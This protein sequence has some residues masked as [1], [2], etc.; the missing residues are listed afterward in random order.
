MNYLGK[1]VGPSLV[2]KQSCMAISGG[3]DGVSQNCGNHQSALLN[4]PESKDLDASPF[5]YKNWYNCDVIT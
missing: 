4:I 5:I 3:T 1:P 2:V